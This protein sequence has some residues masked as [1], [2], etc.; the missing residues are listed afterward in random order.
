MSP[1]LQMGF[2]LEKNSFYLVLI[3]GLKPAIEQ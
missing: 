3:M 2:I 1:K